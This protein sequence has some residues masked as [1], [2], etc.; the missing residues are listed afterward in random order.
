MCSYF[1]R[2]SS[3]VCQ[4]FSTGGSSN[5]DT[6]KAAGNLETKYKMKELGLSLNQKWNTDNVL[7]TE[8]TV[9]DQVSHHNTQNHINKPSKELKHDVLL[10]CSWPRV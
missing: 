10:L 1:H 6:G 3:L 4:E 2:L 7:T 8:V 9:E 5:T